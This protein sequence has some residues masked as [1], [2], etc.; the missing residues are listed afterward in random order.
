[1]RGEC[2]FCSLFTFCIGVSVVRTMFYT[3]WT[4]WVSGRRQAAAEDVL[5][6]VGGRLKTQVTVAVVT[7]KYVFIS[8][9]IPIIFGGAYAAHVI[10][11]IF[12]P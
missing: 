1:M 12:H 8:C 2:V 10:W 5:A 3:K 7:A 11:G 6:C 4:H 9:V